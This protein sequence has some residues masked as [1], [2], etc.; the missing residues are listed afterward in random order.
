MKQSWKGALLSGL[1]LPGAG[2]L[3]QKRYLKGV[4]LILLV[5]TSLLAIVVKA[6]SQA[7]SLLE[8]AESG[9]GTVDMVAIATSASQSSAVSGD[10]LIRGS[11][12]VLIA[13]W[14]VGVVDAYLTGRKLDRAEQAGRQR[15]ED[16]R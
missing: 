3:S 10:L 16:F 15:A 13:C 11:L 2:Q 1:V 8:K 5:T 14:L 12:L 7:L 4:I 9:G 6:T